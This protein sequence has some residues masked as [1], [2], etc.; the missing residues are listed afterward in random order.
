MNTKTL[1][2]CHRHNLCPD[3]SLVNLKKGASIFRVFIP[4]AAPR[5]RNFLNF[6]RSLPVA[7][8]LFHYLSPS[9]SAGWHQSLTGRQPVNIALGTQA[10]S[11]WD[12]GLH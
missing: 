2:H 5:S 9:W 3:L 10:A 11:E 7:G 12:N 6:Y 8:N 1:E 4:I